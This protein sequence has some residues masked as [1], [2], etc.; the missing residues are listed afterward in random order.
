M[1]AS[2]ASAPPGTDYAK[3]TANTKPK[4][5]CHKMNR[6]IGL[7]ATFCKPGRNN[8]PNLHN[9]FMTRRPLR[10]NGA[11]KANSGYKGLSDGE[12]WRNCL[13][14]QQLVPARGLS[15]WPP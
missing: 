1:H 5:C 8:E 15:T 12:L 13:R 2:I 11:N 4:P 9:F 6:R 7:D 14:A 10:E 3:K